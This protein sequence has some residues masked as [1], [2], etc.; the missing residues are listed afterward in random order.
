VAP[1]LGAS[2]SEVRWIPKAVTI[3]SMGTASAR[4]AEINSAM[5]S[6]RSTSFASGEITRLGS[7]AAH[8]PCSIVI[9]TVN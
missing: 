4:R 3:G 6:L 1:A 2:N 9:V 8:A 5:C 7:N